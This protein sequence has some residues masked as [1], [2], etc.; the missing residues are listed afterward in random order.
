MSLNIKL[1]NDT[2]HG[3]DTRIEYEDKD[4]TKILPIMSIDFDHIDANG[5][6]NVTLLLD[7][8][9][10]KY[11]LKRIVADIDTCELTSKELGNIIEEFQACYNRKVK[12]ENEKCDSI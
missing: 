11:D 4:I 12:E 9:S 3:S 5:L 2:G 8:V 10:F 6:V 7:S 1:V